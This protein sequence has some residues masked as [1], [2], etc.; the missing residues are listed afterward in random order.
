[1]KPHFTSL[2]KQQNERLIEL[3]EHGTIQSR[4]KIQETET[5][6]FE[7]IGQFKELEI[8]D[9]REKKLINLLN[10]RIQDDEAV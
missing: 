8:I 6:D 7:F 3:L 4:K 10:Q 1:M 2:S 5:K 9:L